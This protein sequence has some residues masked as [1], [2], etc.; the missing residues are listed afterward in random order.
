MY[1]GLSLEVRGT[2]PWVKGVSSGRNLY[3]QCFTFTSR[4]VVAWLSTPDDFLANGD[5]EDGP[6]LLFL[7]PLSGVL[8]AAIVEDCTLRLRVGEVLYFK[9]SLSIFPRA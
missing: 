2:G 8:T 7:A 5:T 3:E 9:I 1:L 6:R 4:P